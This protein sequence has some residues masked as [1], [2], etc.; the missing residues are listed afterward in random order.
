VSARDLL[1]ILGMAMAVYL[2]KA[3]PLVLLPEPLT[4]RLGGWLPYVAPA[5]LGALVAPSIVF[6][7]VRSPHLGWDQAGFVVAALVAVLTRRV[8]L[9]LA[10]GFAVVVALSA[11]PT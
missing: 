9:S 5:V 11:L 7:Q 10:A 2:P 3:L 6:G 8:V 4:R 1:L